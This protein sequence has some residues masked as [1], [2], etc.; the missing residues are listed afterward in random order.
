MVRVTE[1]A[2]GLAKI[3]PPAPAKV[4]AR[5][6]LFRLLDRVGTRR[7]LWVT[8][9]PGAGKTTLVSGYLESRKLNGI[10]YQIDAGDT[11][12]ASFFYY[13]GSAVKKAAPR[14]RRPL[15]LLTPEYLPGLPVFT[16]RY[17]EALAERLPRPFAL[18]F[19]NYHELPAESPIH[20]VMREG[21]T[22]IPEG[23]VV[24]L[25]SRAVPPMNLAVLQA[26]GQMAV[27]DWTALRLTET[28]TKGM[29]ALRKPGKTSRQEIRLLQT[30]TDGWAAGIILMLERAKLT[31]EAGSS[32]EPVSEAVFDYFAGEIFAK[33]DRPVQEMLLRTAFLPSMT[34]RMAE[35]LTGAR[36]VGKTLSDLTRSNYFVSERPGS[37]RI[38][39]YHDLFREFLLSQ[40][41]ERFSQTEL[42]QIRHRAGTVL[43]S[44]G[45]M[46]EAV[47]LYAG[48][49]DWAT[50]QRIILAQAPVMI[51]QGRSRT[52]E[53]WI[54]RLPTTV[55]EGDP[56]LSYW[57]GMCRSFYDV[58]TSRV[59]LR[60]AFELFQAAGDSEGPWLAWTAIID[61][62]IYHW[63][64]SK[65]LHPWMEWFDERTRTHPTFP[66]EAI[67]VR[68]T[69]SAITAFL[70]ERPQHPDIRKWIERGLALSERMADPHVRARIGVSAL[71]Y[72][73]WIGDY[74]RCR[75]I[76]DR[77][78][79]AIDQ[80]VGMMSSSTMMWKSF[81]GNYYWI[82]ADWEA[83]IRTMDEALKIAQDDGVHAFDS[84]ALVNGVYV[85]LS[86]GR[87]EDGASYLRRIKACLPPGRTLG[88]A[89]YHYMSAWQAIL[90]GDLSSGFEHAK[91]S[92]ELAHEC[93]VPFAEALCRLGLIQVLL[94]RDEREG[95]AAHCSEAYRIAR[96]MKSVILEYQCA[97]TE[98]QTALGLSDRKTDLP[99]KGSLAEAGLSALRRA[100]A[101]GREQG[102]VNFAGWRSSVMARLCA[103]A[104]EH[105][106]EVEYV[107]HLIRKRNLL[108]EPA[109]REIEAWPWP[110]KVYTLGRFSI[111][112]DDQPLAVGRRSQHGKP[113][114]LLK[115]LIA[116][117]GRNVA[118]TDL[119]EALWPE[120]DGDAARQAFDTT[121][122]RLRKLLGEDA[123]ILADGHLTLDPKRVWVDL[124]SVER[125]LSKLD[126][127]LKTT[128]PSTES[129]CAMA[130]K[131]FGLYPGPFLREESDAAWTLGPRERLH[132]RLVALLGD[133]GRCWE[134]GADWER[135]VSCY[136]QGIKVDPLVEPFYQRLMLSYQTL[137]RRAEAL[138]T[139]RRC[140]EALNTH[141]Q[142][143][144]S[145]ATE[146]IHQQIRSAIEA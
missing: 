136:Q 50:V 29:I 105:G 7:I 101:I 9:P 123:A 33:L 40:A 95:V 107:R 97:L 25:I 19:D 27:L 35:R 75:T 116:H 1:Q 15:P 120:A 49:G 26:N 110:V 93:G 64:G 44:S 146:A 89:H 73:V 72:F 88:T 125:I 127:A 131:L 126:Q 103:V 51:G 143:L 106:I 94:E 48:A 3:S 134:R 79:P 76:I 132:A 39:Q 20:D 46:E 31:S 90:T 56:W 70:S 108:P 34:L 82:V 118:Q 113:L 21:L 104:L 17:F 96:G 69:A 32:A 78:N 86:L 2:G 115:A 80:R 59:S 109:A 6:R 141:L 139:Y 100:M 121:L 98:A 58:E 137:G 128:T 111:L 57:L 42:S 63:Q 66:S 11:D 18:V 12:P 74:A 22:Q 54:A 138:S 13:L 65:P 81:V 135:A 124:W 144:P 45:R 99:S 67:E 119:T 24:I 55:I 114:A 140:R 10:W 30:K 145:P 133:L 62:S 117:G 122:H 28:E 112:L 91:Q 52:L 71:N 23:G 87:L 8:G 14:F 85:S 38:Y 41:R 130:E 84:W 60:N 77:M 47:D 102:Y 43:E 37:E 92:V 36:E 83:S 53:S 4:L 5:P 61:A 142:I 129:V 68:V 16:R